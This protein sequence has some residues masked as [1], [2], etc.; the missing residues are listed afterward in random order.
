MQRRRLGGTLGG[1][2]HHLDPS[3]GLYR[4]GVERVGQARRAVHA[5]HGD[6]DQRHF[7]RCQNQPGVALTLVFG[8]EKLQRA[9][10]DPAGREV[11]E[12]LR[13]L[14]M[15]RQR[16]G[17]V[18]VEPLHLEVVALPP[19]LRSE[20]CDGAPFGIEDRGNV[21]QAIGPQRRTH[22]VSH[23]VARAVAARGLDRR[24]G[25]RAMVGVDL[26]ERRRK[27]HGR[28]ETGNRL[29]DLLD[30]TFAVSHFAIV[31]V[32]AHRR[33]EAQDFRCGRTLRQ[34]GAGITAGTSGSQ[35]DDVCLAPLGRVQRDRPTTA[36]NLV[37]RMRRE[38]EDDRV[39]RQAKAFKRDELMFHRNGRL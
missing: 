13:R 6:A 33:G 30:E 24:E 11:L 28:P 29:D 34:P 18:A 8:M 17:A 19:E 16:I 23:Q 2:G 10:V 38:N 35:Q 9:L 26:P 22:L 5:A 3:P 4:D 37:V 27:Q 21:D 32:P 1:D 12:C 20:A 14:H 39:P 15:G 7:R 25:R 36:E 31:E